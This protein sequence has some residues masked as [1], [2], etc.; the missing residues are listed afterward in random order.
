MKITEVLTHPVSI[1]LDETQW[2]AQ[3]SSTHSSV[4]LV[5]VRTDAGISG[6]GQIHAGPMKEVCS[7]VARLGEVAVGM[8]PRAH[9]DVWDTLFALTCPRP[10]AIPAREGVF[11]PLPRSAAR[12]SWLRSP[13]S[14]SR[15]GTSRARLLASPFTGS[16]VA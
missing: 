7:W 10:D 6:V 16:S 14:I 4:I 11:A 8:D 9:T 5:E 2:T 1:A 3:E 12:R 15:Y 13:G